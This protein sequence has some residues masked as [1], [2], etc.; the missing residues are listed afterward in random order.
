MKKM[1]FC[2]VLSIT[3][4]FLISFYITLKD[5]IKKDPCA[6]VVQTTLDNAI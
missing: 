3:L 2:I 1:L 5:K 6:I 4:G